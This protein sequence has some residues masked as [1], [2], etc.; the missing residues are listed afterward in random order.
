MTLETKLRE[1]LNDSLRNGNT[2][3][4]SVIRMVLAAI[5]NAEIAQGKPLD[6]QEI[7]LI[8]AKEVKRHHESIDA[9]FT[10]NRED[11]VSQE[12]ME[13]DILLEYLPKQLNRAEIIA[14]ARD[15]IQEMSA[16]GPRDKGRV[17]S[18][19]TTQL[20]GKAE[21]RMINEVVSELLNTQ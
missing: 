12:K 14:A 19:L 10:G 2:V 5:K 6:D 11:L 21:G 20:K 3:R 7:L 1:D 16:Q 13:L 15:V 9:F 18:R 4:R 8:V 17:M